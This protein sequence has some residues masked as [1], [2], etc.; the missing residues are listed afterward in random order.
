MSNMLYLDA[1]QYGAD[2]S[3]SESKCVDFRFM[4]VG[5]SKGNINRTVFSVLRTCTE[6]AN[7]AF[8]ILLDDVNPDSLYSFN[9]HLK[10]ISTT[11]SICH[12]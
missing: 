10:V 9:K 12:K 2:K 7:C 1:R 4:H 11:V 5:I 8:S 6:L 3:L